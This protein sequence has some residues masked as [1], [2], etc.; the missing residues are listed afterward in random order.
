MDYKYGEL[1][2][3]I[4]NLSLAFGDKLILR[5]ITLKLKDIIRDST[6]GQVITLIGPSGIGKTQLLKMIAGLQAPTSGEIKIGLKQEAPEAGKVGMVLQTYPL[7]EHRT[8]L[9]NLNLVS[10]DKE[11]I[12]YLLNHFDVYQ[13]RNKYPCQLSGGQRQRTA[14]VQQILSS[15]HFILLDEPF[16]GL[17][18]LAT[19]KLSLA[20]RKL[21]DLQ[22]ENTIILSS[23]IFPPA[24][25]VSDTAIMLGKELDK[26]GAT[27]IGYYDLVALGL[28]WNDSIREDAKFLALC[29]QV[30]N[31]FFK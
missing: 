5:D 14:I 30:E 18:P 1:V 13:Q 23:H 22:D 17:D 16:S 2:L 10:K 7:F 21:A 31:E 6:T 25:A 9:S 12:E 24:L 28:A 8:V 26:E 29:N 27:I 3:S 4:D 11:R 15:D 19:R 20:I